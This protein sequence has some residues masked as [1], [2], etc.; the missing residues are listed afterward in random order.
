MVEG[1]WLHRGD[2]K[3]LAAFMSA[4]RRASKEAFKMQTRTRVSPCSGIGVVRSTPAAS[5]SRVPHVQLLNT[6]WWLGPEEGLGGRRCVGTI[7]C[8][9]VCVGTIE[10]SPSR[11]RENLSLVIWPV[12][13]HRQ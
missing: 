3:D 2:T 13:W 8:T 4:S 1:S 11:S 5:L 6:F 10:S 12:P 9:I 7:E